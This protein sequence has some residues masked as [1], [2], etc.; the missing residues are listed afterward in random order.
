MGLH[1]I[2]KESI[3]EQVFQQLKDQIANGNWKPG[4]KLPSETELAGVFGVSRVTIRNALQRLSTMGLVETRFGEGSFVKEADL[5]QQMKAILIPNVY[6]QP[7]SVE[8][9]LQFRCAIE[10]ETAGLAAAK[11]TKKDVQKLK[12]LYK[13]QMEFQG[14][15]AAFAGYDLDFHCVIAQITG[16][17]LIIATYQILQDILRQAMLRTVSSLGSEIGMPYHEA[18]I[19]AIEAGDEHKAIIT[20]KD[21]MRST[22]D[23][24]SK[25]LDLS[26]PESSI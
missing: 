15:A 17:S 25:V 13:K 1:P 18:L 2:K 16:N 10:V 6:L 8:E 4:E 5:G 20:M 21:H 14:D 23:S 26:R 12:R 19:E 22:Y 3:S 24:F 9:V 7:H 11:A